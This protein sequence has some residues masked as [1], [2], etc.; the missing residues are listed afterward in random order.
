VIQCKGTCDRIGNVI[1]QWPL[2]PLFL[3]SNLKEYLKIWPPG[4]KQVSE[5][6]E[7]ICSTHFNIQLGYTSIIWENA[8]L[9]FVIHLGSIFN[10]PPLITNQVHFIHTCKLFIYKP[11]CFDS[12]IFIR[13][14]THITGSPQYHYVNPNQINQQ[15]WRNFNIKCCNTNTKNKIIRISVHCWSW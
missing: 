12:S 1:M 5:L 8:R 4:V 14:N 10:W 6:K 11:I 7:I 13:E 3:E 9:K 2:Y 15:K